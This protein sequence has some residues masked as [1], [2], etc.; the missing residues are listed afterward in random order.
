MDDDLEVLR[1]GLIDAAHRGRF[2]MQF[3]LQEFFD[4]LCRV[5]V[6]KGRHLIKR[7]AQ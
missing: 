7:R 4:A 1:D 2:I 5:E 6:F 3:T